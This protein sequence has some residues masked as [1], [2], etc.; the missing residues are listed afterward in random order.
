MRYNDASTRSGAVYNICTLSPTTQHASPR[1]PSA[2][3]RI[4]GPASTST[5]SRRGMPD[6]ATM[7]PPV[8]FRT[9]HFKLRRESPSTDL[10]VAGPASAPA[11]KRPSR[12][13]GPSYGGPIGGLKCEPSTETID[14]G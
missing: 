14:G 2:D 7:A 1:A 6:P 5:A 4:A 8:G 12:D 9:S 13:T 11:I 10:P 3:R